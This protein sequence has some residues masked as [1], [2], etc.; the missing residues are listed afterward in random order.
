MLMT[1]YD[2]DNGKLWWGIDGIWY[3]SGDPATGLMR[4]LLAFQTMIIFQP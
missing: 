4:L 3:A 2:A 1:A